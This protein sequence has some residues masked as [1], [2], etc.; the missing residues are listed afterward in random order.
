MATQRRLTPEQIAAI[1]RQMQ[2]GTS[3]YNPNQT[4]SYTDPAT[5]RVI[6]AIDG[7][8][9]SEYS[10]REDGNY[11]G[12]T[13]SIYDASGAYD[14]DYAMNDNSM[15]EAMMMFLASVGGM[16]FL[17]GGLMNAG[18]AAGTAGAMGP[19]TAAEAAAQSAALHSQLAPYAAGLSAG[20]VPPNPFVG[21]P[22]AATAAMTSGAAPGAST[23]A[24]TAATTAGKSLLSS[25]PSWLGPAATVAGALLGGKG[26]EQSATSERKMDPRLDPYVF[27]EKGVVP[28]AH[29][30]LQ[31][32]MP[33]AQQYGQQM[34]QV[35]QGLLNMPAAGNGFG[36]F[37]RNRYGS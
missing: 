7:G 24:T 18:A 3:G 2:G 33:I 28:M 12:Q 4:F 16:Q 5:G 10:P 8:G 14:G 13:Q 22:T 11:G 19:V 30:L 25:A 1:Q 21:D 20:V 34:G 29:G 31:Q 27:G 37:T 15:K 23:A 9:Y 36:L 6:Q 26:N 17:P 32:Q 35:G